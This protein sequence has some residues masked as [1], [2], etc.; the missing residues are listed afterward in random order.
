MQTLRLALLAQAAITV[1]LWLGVWQG[2]QSFAWTGGGV[3]TDLLER[4]LSY[5]L[6]LAPTIPVNLVAAVWLGRGGHRARLYLACA[7]VLVAVQQILLL[8]PIDPGGYLAPGAVFALTVGP[9]AFASLALA[10]TPRAKGWLR[11]ARPRSARRVIGVEGLAW[12]LTAVLAVGVVSS[13]DR[14]VAASAETGPPVGA[15]DESDV[16]A[17]METAVTA[18]AAGPDAFPGFDARTVQ[19]TACGYRTD[20]GLR[21][22]RYLLAYELAPFAEPADE[23]AYAQAV[24]E[25][26]SGED[27]Q[28][29][30]DG[31]TAEGD[32]SIRAS[33]EDELTLHLV[34]GEAAA[35]EIR[36]G[37]LERVDP[38]PGCLPAQGGVAPEDDTVEGLLC[39]GK[40]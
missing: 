15:Y 28:I 26:W 17:R 18:T 30:Y 10:L 11:E 1:A 9:V 13:V 23:A 35:L 32:A 39:L 4:S 7:G 19:V 3:E 38:D 2:L 34:L 14:W 22:Y 37:C 40:D 20:A 29:L 31:T 36:S 5:L 6:V 24:R 21:T 33:R 12:G 25:A 8:V 27:Y 16:W